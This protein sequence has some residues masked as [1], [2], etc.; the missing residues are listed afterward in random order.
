V[1]AADT[2]ADG[3][4]GASDSADHIEIKRPTAPSAP[5]SAGSGGS[6]ADGET[7]DHE[8]QSSAPDAGSDPAPRRERSTPS[9]TEVGGSGDLAEAR[10]SLV[11]ALETNARRAERCEDP[12]RAK[13]YL[14]AAREAAEALSALPY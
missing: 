5:E 4:P 3:D 1:E 14:A 11:R 6:V 12:R 7:G 10:A 2:T 9:G 13:E 8:R